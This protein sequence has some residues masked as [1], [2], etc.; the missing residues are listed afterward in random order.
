MRA[1]EYA[2]PTSIADAVKALGGSGSS[3]ALAGGTDL[4][5]R[6]KDDIVRPARVVYV[7]GIPEL[8]GIRV[9]GSVVT[10]GAATRLVDLVQHAAL[11]ELAPAVRQ[12]ALE[13]G[14]PQIRNM[15]T[16]GGN[17]CQ[18]PCDWYFRNG[19]GLLG[20]RK[21]G[22]NLV[23]EL[24]GEYA[25][26]DVEETAH[27][28]RD[29]DNRYAAIFMT[30]G[31]ALYAHSSSLAPPL[32]ALGATATLVGPDGERTVPVAE[33]YRIPQSAGE[34]ELTLRPGELLTQVRF[35][36]GPRNATYEVRQKQSHDWPLVLC[37]VA[38]TMDGDRVSK[39]SV[40]LGSVAPI[41]YRAE[42]AERAIT[43]S[44]SDSS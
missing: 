10:L 26:I 36:A 5:S 40:V 28:V 8:S 20:G 35:T 19:F 32:I 21:Q 11:A 22:R 6:M 41:P 9:E 4:I 24:E 18:R 15:A 34:S 12:A 39:A 38:L 14:S 1:F 33:L 13:V 7:K 31:D 25:P 23:R 29:G 44:S 17:L 3:A 37:S 30:D 2:S 43:C 27:L 16:L 42:A